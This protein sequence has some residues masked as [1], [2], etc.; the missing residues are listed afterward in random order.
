MRSCPAPA[1]SPVPSTGPLTRPFVEQHLPVVRSVEPSRSGV[2]GG[3]RVTIH[4]EG[5]SSDPSLVAVDILGIPC[6]V[7]VAFRGSDRRPRF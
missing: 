3:E 4:G 2:L 1:K 6:K 5:F 7:S